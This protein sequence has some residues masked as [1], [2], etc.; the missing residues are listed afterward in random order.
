M[1]DRRKFLYN[2]VLAAGGLCLLPG[3]LRAQS[4]MLRGPRPFGIQLWSVKDAMHANAAET[5]KQLAAYGYKRIESFEGEKG[6]FWGMKPR[7]FQDYLKSLGAQCMSTHAE[8]DKNLQQK[9]DEA[10]EAGISYLICPWKGPQKKLDDY[11][12]I[13]DEFNTA[14]EVCRKAGLSFAYHN[15]DYSFKKLEGVVPQHLLM[16]NTDA[17]LVNFEMDIYWVVTAGRNPLTE[18]QKFPGRYKLCHVKQRRAN[19]TDTDASTTLEKGVIDF[20]TLLP[21]LEKLGM[22]YQIVEQERYDNTTAMEAAKANARFMQLL[23]TQ[24]PLPLPHV[25]KAG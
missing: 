21:A 12:R 8:T 17:S 23:R 7:A 3:M 22:E 24:K 19:T 10:A 2:S 9:A 13:A 4:K 1:V 16:K 18:A 15:H 20:K 11:K 14:G 25:R 6:M 5:L